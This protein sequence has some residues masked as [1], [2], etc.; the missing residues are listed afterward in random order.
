MRLPGAT[1]G[2]FQTAFLLLH[3]LENFI[4]HSDL[5]PAWCLLFFC[6]SFDSIRTFLQDTKFPLL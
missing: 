1:V 5:A 4:E 6:P 2:A 3:I